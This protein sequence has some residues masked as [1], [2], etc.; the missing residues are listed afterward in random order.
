MTS[1]AA[2]RGL[3]LIEAF[4]YRFHRVMRDA[5][6]AV[7]AGAIGRVVRGEAQFEVAIART[8]GELRWSA[9]QGGGGLM[10]LGC[11][12]LHALRSLL[13]EEPRVSSAQATFEDG[14]DSTLSAEL[15]FPS[16]ATGRIECSMIPERP[17]AWLRLQGEQ[18]SLEIINFLAPQ[19]GCRFSITG[20]DGAA[21]AQPTE[22]SS[23]YAAQLDHVGDVLAGTA[24]P[25]TGGAD[26]VANM[27]AID[28]IYAAA[29]RPA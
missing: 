1:H 18:G 16:G 5:V 8:P 21:K 27:R 24:E 3:P 19:R 6:R 20:A 23:T 13:G 10:D 2:A 14:V 4:H 7:R 17:Q 26:A 12:P 22:G 15:A 28:A 25:L 11:Y 29:G 9:A